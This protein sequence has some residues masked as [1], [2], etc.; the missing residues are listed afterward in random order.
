MLIQHCINHSF[1]VFY[2]TIIHKRNTHTN[3]TFIVDE[4]HL[5]GVVPSHQYIILFEKIRISTP[6]VTCI[7]TNNT[8]LF[9]VKV[10]Y[11]SNCIVAE[12]L[13]IMSTLTS[14]YTCDSGMRDTPRNV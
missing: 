12:K 4:T 5:D 11:V 2:F 10:P 1:R 6:S 8:E 7:Y 9:I 14:R 3:Y 13:H